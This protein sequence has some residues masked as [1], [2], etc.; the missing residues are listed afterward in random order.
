MARRFTS[1]GTGWNRIAVIDTATNTL[2]S[3]LAVPDPLDLAVTPDGRWLY[4]THANWAAVSALNLVYPTVPRV[5]IALQFSTFAIAIDPAGARVYASESGRNGVYVIDTQSNTLV[6]TIELAGGTGGF[7]ILGMAVTPDGSQLFTTNSDH[8]SVVDTSTNTLVTTIATGTISQAL[9]FT[10]GP[11]VR[12]YMTR[13][14]MNTV[15]LKP[16]TSSMMGRISTGVFGPGIAATSGQSAAAWSASPAMPTS[17]GG[18]G[19]ATAVGAD[20]IRRVYAIGGTFVPPNGGPGSGVPQ[21]VVEAFDPVS[22]VWSTA[23]PLP[24]PR[25]SVAAVT[26]ADGRIY[27]V[28]DQVYDPILDAWSP[29]ARAPT[30]VDLGAVVADPRPG[31]KIYAFGGQWVTSG[32]ST[33]YVGT[34]AAYNPLTN[35]WS[36][37][38]SALPTPRTSAAAVWAVR[39]DGKP[40]AYVI[41][42]QVPSGPPPTHLHLTDWK[43]VVEAYD[44]DTNTWT[45]MARMPVTRSEF[46]AVRGDDGRI[47]AIAG[48]H[49]VFDP[50]VQDQV[51]DIAYD[52]VDVYDPI[53][54]SW[55]TG[56]C[57]SS[58]RVGVGAAVGADPSGSGWSIYAIGGF[59]KGSLNLV[60]VLT[61][62]TAL[63]AVSPARAGVSGRTG[64]PGTVNQSSVHA[65]VPVP[66]VR[67]GAPAPRR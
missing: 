23:A 40:R 57:L 58:D 48:R 49:P 37:N 63:T 3:D 29:I 25:L 12:G 38:L 20:G 1:V 21:A 51:A 31:G 6:A 22:Q 26:G 30:N 4:V 14:D 62:P 52:G 53:T 19:V 55:V 43:D 33:E 64:A 10:G 39:A 65:P 17:R 59:G 27:A 54:N 66:H 44:P 15:I 50:T 32:G 47:Y 46:A 61:S 41:G 5:D 24:V 35:T 11:C 28:G 7:G 42:G 13:N 16:L 8:V 45:T 18:M 9:A 36:S 56:S 60:E 67:R 34:S 2:V